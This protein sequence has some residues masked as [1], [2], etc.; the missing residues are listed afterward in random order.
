MKRAIFSTFCLTILAF[1]ATGCTTEDDGSSSSTSSSA[2]A[3][4]NP[5]TTDCSTVIDGSLVNPVKKKDGILGKVSVAGPNLLVM[6]TE[7][8]GDFLVKLHSLGVPYNDAEQAGAERLLEDLAKEDAYFFKASDDCTTSVGQGQT[9]YI[10][11]LFT[12]SGKS[13]SETLLKKA[14][15]KTSGDP[16]SGSLLTTCYRAL[17]ED[18]EASTAGELEAFLWKPVSDSNGKLAIHSSPSDTIIKIGGETGTTQ[19][20]GNGYAQLGRF[21]KPGCA[22]GKNIQVKAYNSKGAPY[23]INGNDYLTIPDG[24]GRYCLKNGAIVACPK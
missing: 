1:A 17:Q 18:A 19:G 2:T 9:G 21:S 24:C 12:T 13:Y 20:G 7:K 5:F 4:T 10:G 22:Y 8:D 11:Q 6:T 14:Y 15:G 16:C 3:T 23:R